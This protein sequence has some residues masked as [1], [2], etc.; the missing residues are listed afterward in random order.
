VLS[1]DTAN[2]VLNRAQVVPIS[3]QVDQLYPSEA[4]VMLNGQPRKAMA[5]QLTTASKRR[6]LRRVGA[7][8]TADLGAVCRVVRQQLGL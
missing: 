4:A 1:I 3:S 6:F 7:I 8:T 2:T 5:D